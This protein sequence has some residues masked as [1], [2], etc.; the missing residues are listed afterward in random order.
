MGGHE[1]LPLDPAELREAEALERLLSARGSDE[2]QESAHAPTIRIARELASDVERDAD[3]RV[4]RLTEAVLAEVAAA[5]AVRRPGRIWELSSWRASLR[6]S[7]MLRVLAASL[8]FHLL[9]LPAIAW[10]WWRP[11]PEPGYVLRIEPD[12]TPAAS[13]SDQPESD[14]PAVADPADPHDLESARRLDRYRLA[15]AERPLAPAGA[16]P[17]RPRTSIDWFARRVAGPLG[18]RPIEAG[19][20]AHAPVGPAA[21]SA[22]LEVAFDRLAADPDDQ[23]ALELALR[24]LSALRGLAAAD[25]GLRPLVLRAEARARRVGLMNDSLPLAD[26]DPTPRGWI[27]VVEPLLRDEPA[28]DAWLEAKGAWLEGKGGGADARR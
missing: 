9:T 26:L 20:L 19:E 4:A 7:T 16:D 24:R 23:R 13:E 10:W 8:L 25:A 27:E 3:A 1:E 17:D 15:R 28:W 11:E 12:A 18:A 14:E 2:G 21:E 5:E 22:A 6:R